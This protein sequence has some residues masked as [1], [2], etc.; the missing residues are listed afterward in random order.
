MKKTNLIIGYSTLQKY[1][2]F[3]KRHNRVLNKN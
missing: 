1:I 2:L 3:I